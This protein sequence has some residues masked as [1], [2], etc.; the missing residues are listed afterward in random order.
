MPAV[1]FFEEKVPNDAIGDR[2]CV[3]RQKRTG[4]APVKR[5]LRPLLVYC[6]VLAMHLSDKILVNNRVICCCGPSAL[7]LVSCA[8][9]A[10][11]R[12]LVDLAFCKA[13]LGQL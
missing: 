6:Q 12:K 3:A 8:C 11:F 5:E 4:M 10:G 9:V 7:I 13:P 1:G 2:Q